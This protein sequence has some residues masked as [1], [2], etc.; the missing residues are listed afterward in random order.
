M[1]SEVKVNFTWADTENIVF[2]NQEKNFWIKIEYPW[3]ISEIF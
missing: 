1:L 3:G 2:F